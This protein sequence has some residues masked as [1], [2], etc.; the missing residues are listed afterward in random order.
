MT[1]A[2]QLQRPLPGGVLLRLAFGT[3]PRAG[4]QLGGIRVAVLR[5]QCLHARLRVAEALGDLHSAQL[6]D[7]VAQRLIPAVRGEGRLGEPLV[8]G[9]GHRSV[10]LV[11]RSAEYGG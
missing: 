10:E 1:L 6:L 11:N 2:T 7:E 9:T 3:R 8:S 4:E 5:D